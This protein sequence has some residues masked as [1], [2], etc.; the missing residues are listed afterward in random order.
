[1]SGEFSV[2][3]PTLVSLGFDWKISGDDNRTAQVEVSYRKK[4]E[5][6]WRRAQPLLRL[7]PRGVQA[8]FTSSGRDPRR[9]ILRAAGAG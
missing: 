2:E 4:G 1:M 8:S 7:P 3:P 6:D 5:A 9:R